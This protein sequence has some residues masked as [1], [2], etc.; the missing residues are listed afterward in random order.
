MQKLRLHQV[1]EDT[2]C[3]LISGKKNATKQH[4]GNCGDSVSFK[5]IRCHTS[6]VADIVTNKVGNHRRVARVIFWNTGFDFTNKICTDICAFGKMPPP[7]RANTEIK[8]APNPRP[9]S[10]PTSPVHL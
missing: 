8:L 6:T 9:M 4:S 5:K 7:R 10:A 2:K 1:L 3:K